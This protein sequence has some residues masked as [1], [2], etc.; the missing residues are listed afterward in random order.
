MKNKNVNKNA[1]IVRK[2]TEYVLFIITKVF[3]I[4]TNFHE[5]KQSYR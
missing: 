2:V 4:F 1:I 3:H 5:S